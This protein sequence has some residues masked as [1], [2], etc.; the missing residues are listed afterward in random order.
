MDMETN[1]PAVT[2]R[3]E[4]TDFPPKDAVIFALPAKRPCVDPPLVGDVVTPA[5]VVSE[6]SPYC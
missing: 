2:V 1:V 6:E 5:T 3:F 4:V